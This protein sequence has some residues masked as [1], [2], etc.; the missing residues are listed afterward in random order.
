MY[1][2]ANLF[3]ENDL[4]NEKKYTI[5][6]FAAVSSEIINKY[7]IK[8]NNNYNNKLINAYD[9]IYNLVLANK[10]NLDEEL[11]INE[12]YRYLKNSA[13]IERLNNIIRIDDLLKKYVRENDK[14]III[15][16]YANEYEE[17]LAMRLCKEIVSNNK[18]CVNVFLI[19]PTFTGKVEL[20][21]KYKDEL[22]KTTS[23]N[24]YFNGDDLIKKLSPDLTLSQGNVIIYKCL[25]EIAF[26]VGANSNASDIN[27]SDILDR[28][29]SNINGNI[30]EKQKPIIVEYNDKELGKIKFELQNDKAIILEPKIRFDNKKNYPEIVFDFKSCGQ[31]LEEFKKNFSSYVNTFKK[32]IIKKNEILKSL[33]INSL[34]LYLNWEEINEPDINYVREHTSIIYIDIYDGTASIKAAGYAN[35]D[36]SLLG[37]HFIEAIIDN[38]ETDFTNI[39]WDLS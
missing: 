2:N 28:L 39:E 8:N 6:S 21:Q 15:H 33:Y 1:E 38:N 36:E 34:E 27:I 23:K 37:G 13:D 32:I 22:L 26:K 25:F 24:Y 4:I 16:S 3:K 20:F 9:D 31:T 5:I 7:I 29:I 17:S 12:N 14:I 10:S 18:E 35:E 19:P 30:K 11:L